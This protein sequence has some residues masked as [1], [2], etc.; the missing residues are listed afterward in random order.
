[1]SHPLRWS[2]DDDD[3]IYVM[4][5]MPPC[6]VEDVLIYMPLQLKLKSSVFLYIVSSTLPKNETSA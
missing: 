6:I 2:K 3:D 5:T 4:K 1:M